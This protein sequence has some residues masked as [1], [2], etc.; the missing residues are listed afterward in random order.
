MTLSR[1]A[2][3][4]L[5]VGWLCCLLWLR[6]QGNRIIVGS[7]DR[8]LVD[9]GHVRLSLVDRRLVDSLLLGGSDLGQ[10]H[11]HPIVAGD[12]VIADG[13]G[14]PLL[15]DVADDPHHAAGD[16]PVARAQEE[17]EGEE[18]HAT[19]KQRERRLGDVEEDHLDEVIHGVA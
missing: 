16:K 15:L 7:L 17:Q 5:G 19:A 18:D 1:V 12:R 6:G 10:R 8:H 3:V 11:G 2:V 4:V 9:G 13:H 14:L